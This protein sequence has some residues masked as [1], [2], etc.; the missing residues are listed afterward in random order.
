LAR[1]RLPNDWRPRAYQRGLWDYLEN[2]GKRAMAI[3]HRRSGKDAVALH[4]AAVSAFQKPGNYWHMLP[5]AAQAR[6]AIWEAVNP[7]TGRRRVDE[8]FP[9][10]ICTKRD[11]DMAVKFANGATWQVVGSDNFNSLVGSTPI[12]IV[13]S[14]WAL[15]VP[16]AW[17]ILRPILLENG[18]WSLFIT[19]PRGK[20]HAHKMFVGAQKDAGWYAEQ[21]TAHQTGV[22]TPEQL[23]GERAEYEREYGDDVGGALFE[24]E[25]LCSF[26]A[27]ILGSYWGSEIRALERAGRLT[28]FDVVP[29]L[30][31]HTAWDLGVG[32]STAIWFFQV[33][34][35]EIRVIDYYEAHGVGLPHYAEKL[36]EKASRGGWTYGDDFVPHDAKV[37]EL[38]TGRTRVE[39]LIELGRKPR[40]VPDHRLEDGIN[41][42][43]QTFGRTWFR[44]STT[45]D[46]VEGLKA[47]QREYDEEH[48]VYRNKPLHNWASH[49][50]DAWRYLSMA[51]RAIAP[52]EPLPRRP[53]ALNVG[54]VSTATMDDLWAER[55]RE[56][57]DY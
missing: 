8:A 41:A 27:A 30:P 35:S 3:W 29:T 42:A 38:G 48:R 55:E 5:Q 46:A 26:D 47:Y 21:L 2:G 28:D 13:F 45:E 36:T 16:T 12:G 15:A 50:A 49:R 23:A 9:D 11:T 57:E 53:G 44:K 40:L 43:R 1:V 4:W 10:S 33:L 34:G 22:F 51:W 6:K 52:P 7:H 31:V 32:D 24:Q 37:R 25:Y 19:T 18:G 39:T 56:M 54:G 20:N 14:E 17:A